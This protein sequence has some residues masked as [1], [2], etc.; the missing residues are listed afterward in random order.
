MSALVAAKFLE[1]FSKT[2]Y[3]SDI[4]KMINSAMEIIKKMSEKSPAL[5]RKILRKR[6]NECGGLTARVFNQMFVQLWATN[7]NF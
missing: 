4:E 3:K 6:Y 1:Y 7:D 2:K 5:S